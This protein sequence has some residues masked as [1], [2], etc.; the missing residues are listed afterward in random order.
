[1]S[2]IKGVKNGYPL[3]IEVLKVFI[4]KQKIIFHPKC[5][6]HSIIVQSTNQIHTD[7]AVVST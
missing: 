3:L 7:L 2:N 4:I 6:K 5:S 1:M